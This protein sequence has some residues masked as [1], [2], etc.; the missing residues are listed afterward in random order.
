MLVTKR[1]LKGQTKLLTVNWMVS[2]S[3]FS[4]KCLNA[5]LCQILRKCS[6]G[7]M[8]FE[9]FWTVSLPTRN[10]QFLI[11]LFAR[12]F[13]ISLRSKR[14][15]LVSEQRETEGTG[16]SVLAA[17]EMERGPLFYSRHFSRG[18]WLSF[19]VLCSQTARERLLC[20][21]LLP[22]TPFHWRLFRTLRMTPIPDGI[23]EIMV[24]FSSENHAQPRPLSSS[25]F[26]LCDLVCAKSPFHHKISISLLPGKSNSQAKF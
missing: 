4:R 2:T 22:Q 15:R 23:F 12:F 25:S 3:F 16:L 10:N 21:L 14:F 11:I 1:D 20:R 26:A 19:L 18:L 8:L 6:W 24:V 13:Y 5:Y 7:K 9:R 17:R